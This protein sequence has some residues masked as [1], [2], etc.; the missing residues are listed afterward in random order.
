L[1]PHRRFL[2]ELSQQTV[3]VDECTVHHVLT[4]AKGDGRD[5]RIGPIA[6]FGGGLDRGEV[7]QMAVAVAEDQNAGK[8]RALA[9]PQ[10]LL[11]EGFAELAESDFAS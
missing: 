10:G 2:R 6:S 3:D 11:T 1:S 4:C 7:E 9:Q 5:G 8:I